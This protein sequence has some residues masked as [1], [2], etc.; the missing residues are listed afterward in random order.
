[1]KKTSHQNFTNFIDA[2]ILLTAFF[3]IIFV[4]ALFSIFELF[5]Y[6]F[7]K[8]EILTDKSKL[9]FDIKIIM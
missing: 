8:K 1:M 2:Y 9:G 3:F 6:G 5:T 4:K 7:L